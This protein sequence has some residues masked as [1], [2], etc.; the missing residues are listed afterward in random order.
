MK[1]KLTIYVLILSAVTLFFTI[2][3]P[4]QFVAGFIQLFL[5]PGMVFLLFCR[6]K[7]SQYDNIAYSLILSPILMTILIT[8]L[9]MLS[10]DIYLSMRVTL[11]VFY[12][13]LIIAIISGKYRSFS[14]ESEETVPRGVFYVSLMYGGLILVSY[15]VN[16]FLLIR[17]DAWYHAAV[18][19]EVVHRGIPPME[20][21]LANVP[22]KYMWFYHLFQACWIRQSGLSLFWAMGWFNIINAIIFPYFFARFASLF[23]EKKYPIIFSTIL[24]IIGLQAAS[25]ILFPL[26]FLRVFVGE[27]KGI[28]EIKRILANMSINGTDIMNF[29]APTGTWQ[30]NFIDKF[31]TIT[32]FG[33]SLNL[34]LSCVIL[35]LKKKFLG[36]ERLRSSIIIL[37]IILGTFLF[38]IVTGVALITAIIGSTVLIY[39]ISRLINKDVHW[40]TEHR[41]L[42]IVSILTALTVIPYFFSLSSGCNGGGESPRLNDYLHFG[43]RNIL[44]ILLPLL[45]LFCP[46]KNALKKIFAG[47]DYRSITL[48]YLALSVF[49][50]CAIINIGVVGEKKLVFLFFLLIGPPVF[51]EI[52]SKVEGYKKSR[53]TGYIIVLIVLFI[54]PAFLLFRGFIVCKPEKEVDVI[55]YN[56]ADKDLQYLDWIRDNTPLNALIIEN[57]IYHFP[58]VYAGR[59]NFY[60]WYGVI[61][62]FYSSCDRLEKYKEIQ[63]SLYFQKDIGEDLIRKMSEFEQPLYIAVWSGDY[64]SRPWLRKRF[65]IESRFF[66]EVYSSEKVSIYVLKEDGSVPELINNM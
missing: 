64:R 35:T 29:L 44:T 5:L 4:L 46:A 7:L 14:E 27:V 62:L 10:G 63:N 39:I 49:I 65:G 61:R 41:L 45:I 18:T 43:I 36:E 8:M 48:S 50:L 40:Y 52:Y 12:I 2:P 15:L 13:L 59:R 32:A 55:R 21:L 16:D 51:I 9:D 53:R 6:L 37:V 24:G 1:S 26:E 60:S 30:V 42:L 47:R 57:N 23:T 22:I 58:P 54:V 66:R 33:Y 25:W 17:S 11:G 20:P 3:Q 56:S 19:S 28:P 31:I 34:F 38:H